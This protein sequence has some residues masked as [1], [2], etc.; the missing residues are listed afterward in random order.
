MICTTVAF[1][2]KI[3]PVRYERFQR[4]PTRFTSSGQVV[5]YISKQYLDSQVLLE[6]KICVTL[7][8]EERATKQNEATEEEAIVT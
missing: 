2:R 8:A 4:F 1:S 6:M 5:N 7:G 3:S